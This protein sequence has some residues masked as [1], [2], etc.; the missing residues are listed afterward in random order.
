MSTTLELD[1]Y[2]AKP[3]NH[4]ST[5]REAK[6][7]TQADGNFITDTL[8]DFLGYEIRPYNGPAF[9]IASIEVRPIGEVT[10]FFKWQKSR[11]IRK[12]KFLVLEDSG[13]LPYD[14]LLGI[15]FICEFEVYKFNGSLFILALAPLSSGEFISSWALS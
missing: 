13:N 6:L 2:F 8:V 1:I 7:D 10:I 5:S 14:I 4:N 9:Q 3:N 15:R 12:K 11:K